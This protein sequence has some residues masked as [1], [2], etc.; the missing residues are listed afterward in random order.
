[1]GL[2]S[3]NEIHDGRSAEDEVQQGKSVARLT[4][5]F[6]AI[7]SS[8]YDDGGVVVNGI[9][10]TGTPHPNYPN[11]FLIRRNAV[12]ENKGKRIWIATLSYSS[13]RPLR[14]NPLADPAI[15]TWDSEITQIDATKDRDG[16]AIL[17][18]AGDPFQDTLKMDRAGWIATVKKNLASRPT[19]MD[20]Y[21][22][23]LNDGA[24]TVDGYTVPDQHARIQGLN[25]GEYQVRNDIRFRVVTLKIQILDDWQRHILDQGMRGIN[26]TSMLPGGVTPNPNYGKPTHA[27]NADGTLCSHPV[28]LD[29]A[30]HIL[31]NPTTTNAHYIDVD[32]YKKKTYNIL[33]LS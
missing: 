9:A 26:N 6:R 27:T 19:W 30:G 17:N 18:S 28:P 11:L 3:Y 14:D 7:T 24:F 8:P 1:M 15:I 29:G 25:I 2:L 16:K 13:E 5:R 4:R 23:A 31:A 12:P 32:L 22:L 10:Q 33:P 21:R 20:D